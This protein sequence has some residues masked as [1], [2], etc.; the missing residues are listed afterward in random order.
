M[1]CTTQDCKS[2][3]NLKLS[4]KI[5]IEKGKISQKTSLENLKNPDSYK[6]VHVHSKKCKFT[7]FKNSPMMMTSSYMTSRKICD[8]LMH[9]NNC[10]GPLIKM[11]LKSHHREWSTECNLSAG[12]CMHSTKHISSLVFHHSII[13]RKKKWIKKR[14]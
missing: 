3:L 11:C 4:N 1:I 12:P 10:E 9:S 7:K 13:L 2:S 6:V 5:N 8:S 14:F